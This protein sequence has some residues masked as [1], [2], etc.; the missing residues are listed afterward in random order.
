M[1]ECGIGITEDQRRMWKWPTVH[2]TQPLGHE[3]NHRQD[4]GDDPA[5][6]WPRTMGRYQ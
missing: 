2:C 3:G 4:N 5:F 1:A 6:V